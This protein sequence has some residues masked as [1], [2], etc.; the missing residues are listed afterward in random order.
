MAGAQPD[1]DVIGIEVHDPGVAT[2]LAA[3]ERE[4]LRNVRVVHACIDKETSSTR[5]LAPGASSTASAA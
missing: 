2:V 4:H 1:V 5:T 3:V